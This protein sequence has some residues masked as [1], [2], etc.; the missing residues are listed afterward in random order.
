MVAP[1]F[2]Q[3]A[4]RTACVLVTLCLMRCNSSN[5]EGGGSKQPLSDGAT[6]RVESSSGGSSTGGSGSGGASGGSAGQ[7]QGDA[8]DGSF[9]CSGSAADYCSASNCILTWPATL[10]VF[11][12]NPPPF[13]LGG[14]PY[15]TDP[16][17]NYHKVIIQGVDRQLRLY[18]D[19]M[20]GALVTL[21]LYNG[22]TGETSCLGPSDFQEPSCAQGSAVDC[23]APGPG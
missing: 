23:T 13:G 3:V 5:D 18:Y 9:L 8:N 7:G 2:S 21:I 16:C 19:G 17:G 12:S 4:F 1:S 22:N 20:N 11:C 10:Q 15:L 14:V 6:D